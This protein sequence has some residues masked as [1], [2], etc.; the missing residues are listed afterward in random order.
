MN[1]S[2]LSHLD[3]Y[4]TSSSHLE[5]LQNFKLT[6]VICRLIYV[7]IEKAVENAWIS[8]QQYHEHYYRIIETYLYRHVQVRCTFM[9]SFTKQ[10]PNQR[11]KNHWQE[12]VHIAKHFKRN[13]QSRLRPCN[14]LSMRDFLINRAIH[15]GYLVNN[16]DIRKVSSCLVD[17]PYVTRYLTYNHFFHHAFDKERK[18][19]NVWAEL[20][21]RV[22]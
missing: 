1:I 17:Y 20:V 19:R 3:L 16:V 4:A 7:L 22:G 13:R 6:P 8:I 11:V 15:H 10:V 9:L 14:T 2:S 5:Y 18:N 12:I 21:G